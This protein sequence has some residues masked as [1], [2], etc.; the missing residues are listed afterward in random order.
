MAIL[1]Y[2]ELLDEQGMPKMHD[3]FFDQLFNKN[4]YAKNMAIWG[5]G[6]FAPLLADAG[7]LAPNYLQIILFG[8]TIGLI[9]GV[10]LLIILAYKRNQKQ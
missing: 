6:E 9:I 3:E 4:Y 5:E 7:L 1:A 10:L 2:K 8:L